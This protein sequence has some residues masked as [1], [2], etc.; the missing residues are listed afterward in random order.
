MCTDSGQSFAQAALHR[1]SHLPIMN[2]REEKKAFDGLCGS[3]VSHTFSIA[4]QH[5]SLCVWFP[6]VTTSQQRSGCI[7]Q[8]TRACRISSLGPRDTQ[9][10]RQS[11][12][13]GREWRLMV[14]GTFLE[15]TGTWEI[16]VSLQI[17]AKIR[18]EN[19]KMLTMIWTFWMRMTGE[20]KYEDYHS[21]IMKSS[22]ASQSHC[23]RKMD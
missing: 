7:E 11:K 5:V 14:D 1:S 17:F 23:D 21:I 20:M 9:S 10:E 13:T 15:L 2:F 19:I 8:N 4:L 6:T 22:N 12:S 16:H 3:T 18:T